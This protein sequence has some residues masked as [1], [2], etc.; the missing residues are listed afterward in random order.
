LLFSDKP[1]LAKSKNYQKVT[2]LKIFP[3]AAA[4]DLHACLTYCLPN[5]SPLAIPTSTAI[6]NKP[7]AFLQPDLR[8]PT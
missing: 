1:A 2:N 8:P 4:R 6:G 5:L 7:P 3:D